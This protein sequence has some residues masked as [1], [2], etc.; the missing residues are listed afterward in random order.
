MHRWDSSLR[1]PAAGLHP[2]G[3]ADA[4]PHLDE[5]SENGLPSKSQLRGP[6][7][8]RSSHG[9]YVPPEVELPPEQRIAEA[10]AL[11]PGHGAL[12]GWAAA[13]WHGVRLLDGGGRS[14]RAP[15]PVLLCLG[16][17]GKIRGRAHITPS[18]DR[19]PCEDVVLVRGLPTTTPLRTAFDGARLAADLRE[20]VVFVD[21]ML[22]TRLIS[23]E[24]LSAYVDDHPGWQGIQQAR[25]ACVLAVRGSRSPP[26]TRVRMVWVLD[27]GLPTPLVNREVFAAH[28][29]R[30]L[31]IPDCLEQ[32]S[33]TAL[34]YDGDDHR[35]LENHTQDNVR[36]ELLEDH[37]LAVVRVA[38]L[39][40]AG[41]RDRLVHRMIRTHVR[42][43]GRNLSGDRWTLEPPWWWRPFD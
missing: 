12:G 18:R 10:A 27:A 9:R 34:E 8:R 42:Q 23:W 6:K 26:E 5:P 20:A 31:G 22:T 37:G 15:A 36:E 17:Q 25:D 32:K 38:R 43:L 2:V 39:D 13:Y 33:A 40:L 7:W 16:A 30:L 28:D 3:W 29:G 1:P 4:R 14:G 35:D 41:A 21:M 11:L 24:S 19:L